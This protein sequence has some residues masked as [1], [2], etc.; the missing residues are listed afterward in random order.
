MLE[1]EI[2]AAAEDD[3]FAI[4]GLPRATTTPAAVRQAYRSRAVRC[5]PDKSA[6]ASSTAAFQR[7]SAAFE[8]L[9]DEASQRACLERPTTKAPAARAEDEERGRHATRK[10]RREQKTR[11]WAD[12]EADLRRREAAE[13]ALRSAFVSAQRRAA[14]S[15]DAAR[16]LGRLR[17]IARNLD[18]RAGVAFNA[19]WGV[20][21]TEAATGFPAAA[22]ADRADRARRDGCPT[23]GELR[24]I[25]DD[26]LAAEA[27]DAGVAFA[28]RA[29]EDQVADL[30]AYLAEAHGW[31][32]DDDDDDDED[33]GGDDFADFRDD[34]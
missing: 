28:A 23:Y 2:L 4:L 22:A 14:A 27:D 32:D 25:A 3:Y 10:R 29:P 26:Q 15:R 31:R 8:A 19:R 17:S 9:Y 5:H 34:W 18:A 30:V 11:S 12:V 24:R 1:D 21:R 20:S 7:L 6:H 16:R 13:A 33:D